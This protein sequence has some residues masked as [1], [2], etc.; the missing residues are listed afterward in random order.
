MLARQYDESAQTYR[1]VLGDGGAGAADRAEEALQRLAT[2]QQLGG[3]YR[4][5]E[6]TCQRFESRYPKSTL[7]AAVLFRYAENAY[8][9][10]MAAAAATDP[11]KAA[12]APR[13]FAEAITRYDRVLKQYPDFAHGNLAKQGLATCHMRLGHPA[14]AQK[15]LAGIAESDRVGELA[16][17]PYLLA[18]CCIRTLP[19]EAEDAV[20]ANRM[21]DQAEQAAKLLESFVATQAK[22]PQA[23]DAFLKLGYCYERMGAVLAE[24]AERQ[25]T[26][27][28][29]R[30]AFETCLQQYGK[31]PTLPAATLE[32]AKVLAMQGEVDVAINEL[33]KFQQEPL[34]SSPV[35]PLA[36]ARLMALLRA[37]NRA[38]EGIPI[39]ADFRAQREGALLKDPARA[40]WVPMLQ[41]EHA[42]ALKETGKAAEARALFESIAAKFAAKPEGV[43]AA[44]RAAQCRREDATAQIASA[45]KTLTTAKGEA[46]VTAEQIIEDQ[47][48]QLHKVVSTLQDLGEAVGKKA[49]GGE[50]ALRILYETAWCYRVL[51]E[52]EMDTARLKLEREG[53]EKVQGRLKES[54]Q[55]QPVPDLHLPELPVSVVPVQP[56]EKQ[57]YDC[58]KKL[59]AAAPESS[60]SLQA[61]Y[62]L[63]EMHAQRGNVTGALDLLGEALEGNPPPDLTVRIKL[64]LAATLLAKKEPKPALVQ[65]QG[66]VRALQP[67]PPAQPQWVHIPM[68]AEAKY[69]V[70]EA[71]IQQGN[72]AAAVEQLSL[73][74]DQEAWQAIPN[75]SDRALLR[76]GA[77][78][79]QTN[80][81][82]PSRQ[83]YELLSRR[84][85]Q[86][87][88]ADEAR[89]GMGWALQSAQQY[90]DAIQAYTDVVRRT[91]AEVAARCQLQI[92]ACRLAQKKF[93][94][95]ATAFQ[96]VAYT[97]DYPD[98]RGAA[99]CE[100]AKAFVGANQP[101]EAKK[102]LD[103]VVKEMPKTKWADMAKQRLGEIK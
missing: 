46:W 86:S 24:P 36:L 11:D 98:L 38:A 69:L 65:A 56:S 77:A 25:K 12:Q 59:I 15:A 94:E 51:A 85:P 14:E 33:R 99:L 80:Q 20:G 58:Y 62:E 90:D 9:G 4:E 3:K 2:A 8:L 35:A 84:F 55:G 63:A 32:R 95:A 10:A 83:A 48:R 5:S 7:L 53:L 49:A 81:W 75:I 92:G 28:Q 103:R 21:I 101:A 82:G 45:R 96:A 61:R 29:A 43:N 60:L 39:L 6:E 22:A 74:R 19:P 72:W 76:L 16:A 1:L 27:Q 23:P 42:L 68:L 73:F 93:P 102:A 54:A 71:L 78:L 91:A 88:L 97:Y 26:L 70:G 40:D 66:V 67:A 47:A 64:R 31:T 100:A 52:T 30:Q 87:P 41:Y 37:Q 34:M 79:A 18:D 89:Y 17:V 57:A 50:A 13:L 44:W